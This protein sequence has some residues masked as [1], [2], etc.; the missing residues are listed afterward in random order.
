M[1]ETSELGWRESE[2]EASGVSEIK[3]RFPAAVPLVKDIF[4][5]DGCRRL[6]GCAYM[7]KKPCIFT[8]LLMFVRRIYFFC[9]ITMAARRES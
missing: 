1:M 3:V 4:S 7:R 9:E 5:F 8:G 6:T 2:A